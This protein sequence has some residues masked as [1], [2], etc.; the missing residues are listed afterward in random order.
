M[1]SLA[2]PGV[3]GTQCDNLV[4]TKGLQF[5]LHDIIPWE[6]WKKFTNA[7]NKIVLDGVGDQRFI[8]KFSGRF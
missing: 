2:I 1:V 5:G 4:C 7:Q 3:Q 6:A 8:E